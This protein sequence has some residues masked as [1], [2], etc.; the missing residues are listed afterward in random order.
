MDAAIVN[1]GVPHQ[2]PVSCFDV[3]YT[4]TSMLL[5]SAARPIIATYGH[6][7]LS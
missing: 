2:P 4:F 3:V 6:Q 5:P 7:N 1:T